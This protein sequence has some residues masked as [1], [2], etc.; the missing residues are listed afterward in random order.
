MSSPSSIDHRKLLG[1]V[2]T[3]HTPAH[4]LVV[5]NAPCLQ[6]PS[7][8][9]VPTSLAT[10]INQ[11]GLSPTRFLGETAR[12][13]PST[14]DIEVRHRPDRV[15]DLGAHDEFE[16][17]VDGRSAVG[18]TAGISPPDGATHVIGNPVVRRRRL[19]TADGGVT[20][21]LEQ[22]AFEAA[23]EV[24]LENLSRDLTASEF[25]LVPPEPVAIPPPLTAVLLENQRRRRSLSTRQSLVLDLVEID[26]VSCG[27]KPIGNCVPCAGSRSRS[28]AS[29]AF[30]R[31][32]LLSARFLNASISER[33][34]RTSRCASRVTRGSRSR[35]TSDAR[36]ACAMTRAFAPGL[37][38]TTALL[39]RPLSG[40]Q[41]VELLDEHGTILVDRH[42]PSV[43]PEGGTN[44]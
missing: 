27:M 21:L 28:S 5:E 43:S 9:G 22:M 38:N 37:R 42:A 31:A 2:W 34:V 19:D 29:R 40:D 20:G 6:R 33:S 10:W 23:V 3:T 1:Q 39:V 44:S 18:A 7:G 25:R 36:R 15:G 16:A 14:F 41:N 11:G 12:A 35:K 4:T 17:D 26:I 8:L 13:A 24:R 32:C 30:V